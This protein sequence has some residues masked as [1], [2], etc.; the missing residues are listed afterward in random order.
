MRC[1]DNVINGTEV[2]DPAGRVYV[3]CGRGGRRGDEEGDI[4][5][6]KP[7]DLFGDDEII[8][9]CPCFI[10]TRTA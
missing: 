2:T 9:F 5:N 3:G 4:L 8:L 7:Y 10:Q 1:Q 6:L